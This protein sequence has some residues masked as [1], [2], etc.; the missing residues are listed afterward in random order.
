MISSVNWGRF[1]MILGNLLW[2]NFLFWELFWYWLKM[3]RWWLVFINNL[4]WYVLPVVIYWRLSV[5][6]IIFLCLIFQIIVLI[7]W[8]NCS[9]N[10]F[11][12]SFLD[13][14]CQ[15]RN[16]LLV[17]LIIGTEFF[18]KQIRI[19]INVGFDNLN[20]SVIKLNF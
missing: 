17:E 19:I 13:V 9:F 20:F 10:K 1:I 4:R 14:S 11:L 12:D 8:S 2:W 3:F 18:S 6:T 15:N 5:D 16:H 7:Y